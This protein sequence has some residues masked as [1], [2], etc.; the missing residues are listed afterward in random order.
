MV[1]LAERAERLAEKLLPD[2]L[3]RRWRHVQAVAIKASRISTG[4]PADDAEILVASAWLH[5]IGYVP[6]LAITGLHALDGAR[7]IRSESFP[8][9][10]CGLV[11]HHSCAIFEAAERNLEEDLLTDFEDE[12]SPITD[13][14]WYADMTTGPD[15]ES[16]DVAD[17]LNEV[18]RR[19][20]PDHLVTRFWDRAEPTLIDAVRRTELRLSHH[21]M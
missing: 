19:Y 16:L 18:R 1:S 11:A 12:H 4:L 2:P 7:Y 5:D 13:A 3:P 21:P 20:G 17:R 9:R 8:E 15:G 6:E 10:V 14:L